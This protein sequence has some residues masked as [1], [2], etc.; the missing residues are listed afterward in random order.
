MDRPR[1][2]SNVQSIAAAATEL[3]ASS[4]KSR[5]AL[6]SSANAASKAVAGGATADATVGELSRSAQH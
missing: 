1:A 5:R 4:R 6:T 2:P 3:S